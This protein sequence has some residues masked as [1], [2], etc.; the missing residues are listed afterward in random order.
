MRLFKWLSITVLIVLF[1][2]RSARGD[3]FQ[4]NNFTSV[5]PG[6]SI[7]LINT[8]IGFHKL[9]WNVSGTVTTCTVALDSSVDG[10][11]WTPGGVIGGQLCTTNGASTIVNVVSN[12]VRMNMTAFSGTGSVSV[13]WNGYVNNPP[14]GGVT[15]LTGDGTIITNVGS[16]GAVTLTTG[17]KTGTGNIVLATSPVLT[18]PN[19]GAATGT[20]LVTT[21]E[22]DSG[23]NGGSSGVFGMNGSTSGKSTF[24]APAVAGTAS[25]AIAV[26]NGINLPTG[27]SLSFNADTFLSRSS[28]NVFVVGNAVGASNGSLTGAGL[29]A[30]TVV[31]QSLFKVSNTLISV[32]APTVAAAGCGGA[33]AAIV[34]GH[35]GTAAFKVSVG[36]TNTGTCTITMPAATTDWL[37]GATDITTTSTA[38]AVT[39]AKPGGTPTTQVT[40]Q[41]Y[42]DVM[43]TGPWT[44]N[45]VI[46]VICFAE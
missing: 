39:K 44:D 17:T 15:S 8:G 38:V 12:Y 40:L 27:T 21:G 32:T 46:A 13:T 4:S 37:C 10:V 9:T 16:T 34:A 23:S 5:T 45:D 43:A 2:P 22:I 33:A 3:G 7:R 41:N 36:T 18:T 25:N 35:N 19:I 42:T 29:T 24:T 20:S 11:T 31:A 30:S 26:S 6:T 28:A 1:F 14:V